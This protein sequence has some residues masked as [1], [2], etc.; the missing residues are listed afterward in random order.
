MRASP[1][2]GL[3]LL[4]AALGLLLVWAAASA[5]PAALAA[6]VRQEGQPAAV[7]TSLPDQ[8]AREA[9]EISVIDGP[10]PSCVLPR[11][12]TDAC[13]LT[14]SY[15]SASA[16]PNY[17]I[18]MTVE[19]DDQPRARYQG[20]F[21]TS[22]Y[23]PSEMLFFRVPCGVP[24]SSEVVGAGEDP[25]NWGMRHS[26]T[27][28]G[29]DTAGLKA[30]NY[31]SVV[32]PADQVALASA[33]LTGPTEGRFG[34]PY[35]FTAAVAPLTATLPVTYTWLAEEHP[36][37]TDVDGTAALSRAY[38]WESYG[39]KTVQ[40]TISNPVDSLVLSTTIRVE[41]YSIYTPLI[42]KMP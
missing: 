1:R 4:A 5:T 3:V 33:S 42:R 21:Q 40:L 11:P 24:G 27:V 38:S 30:A 22:M 14:W 17:M 20:F 15:L 6:R 39:L 2:Y 29:R 9:P 32:C 13:Y 34:L 12:G 26:Y 25:L 37:Q 10:A 41:P 16:S 35:T 23:V 28:R 7:P 31:G 8:P 19:I 18:T 36:P